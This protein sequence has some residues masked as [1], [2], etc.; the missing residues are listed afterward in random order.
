MVQVYSLYVCVVG[1]PCGVVARLLVYDDGTPLRFAVAENDAFLYEFC[2][3]GLFVIDVSPFICDCFCMARFV[4]D[5][6]NLLAIASHP[7]RVHSAPRPWFKLWETSA[8][9][10]FPDVGKSAKG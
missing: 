10:N 9:G 2:L 4:N 5:D 8:F 3:N 6:D 1:A 7:W